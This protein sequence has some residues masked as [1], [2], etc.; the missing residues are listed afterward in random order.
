MSIRRYLLLFTGLALLLANLC[1]AFWIYSS[2]RHEVAELFDAQLA[3][4]AR[5]LPRLLQRFGDPEGSERPIV[6]EPQPALR[7]LL[8]EPQMGE[9]SDDEHDPYLSHPYESKLAFQVWNRDQVLLILTESAPP[10]DLAQVL[11]GFGLY[12]QG[13]HN[14]RTFTLWDETTA[15]WYWVAE[16][17]DVRGELITE[18]A[19]S[20][21][22]PLLLSLPLVLLL[23]GWVIGWGLR[24][25]RLL[26]RQVALRAPDTL[27]P[28]EGDGPWPRELRPL[29]QAI[30]HLLGRLA[31]AL[32]Q[33]RRF[34]ADAAHELRTP[35]AALQIQLDNARQTQG[36]EQQ[37]AFAQLQRVIERMSRTLHQM[38]Q[39]SRL[40]GGQIQLRRQPLLLQRLLQELWPAWQTLAEH[41]QIA[42]SCRCEPT[43][44]LSL[45]PLALEALLTNL[46][47]NA[48]NYTP[49]G[50]QVCLAISQAG[51][52]LRIWVADNGKGI[53]PE[54]RER[55]LQRFERLDEQQLGGTGLGLSIVQRAVELHQ[56]RI[57]LETGLDGQ[58]LGVWV[59]LSLPA[60]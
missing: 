19:L 5:V 1:V 6:I 21:T 26:S 49:E 4:S 15:H 50:G 12:R 58:G 44:P 54:D 45:Y 38:L 9:S 11:P 39:L 52:L 53:A 56:G 40:E 31:Q 25:L 47:G 23:V 59:E 8:P 33:E 16:R 41:K 57:R 34:S 2:A 32:D 20:T 28:I 60:A 17:L 24:P 43:E 29:V 35:L 22:L 18:I 30:N 48:L 27:H 37:H 3:Q 51:N 14:W 36:L 42:L 55:A 10:L 13:R 7:P 46:V